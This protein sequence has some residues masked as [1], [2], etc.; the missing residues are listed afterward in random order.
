M[1]LVDLVGYEG[2]KIKLL[3]TGKKYAMSGKLI[4]VNTHSIEMYDKFNI[5]TKVSISHIIAIS[6]V[7]QNG[8]SRYETKKRI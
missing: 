1:N 8:S 3:L 7:M 2:K 6:E 5:K 4:K